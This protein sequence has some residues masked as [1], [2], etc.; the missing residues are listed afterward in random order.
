MW[1]FDYIAGGMEVSVDHVDL[2]KIQVRILPKD[3]LA[4]ILKDQGL[5]HLYLEPS[6]RLGDIRSNFPSRRWDAP[7]AFETFDEKASIAT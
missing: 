2:R 1:P 4:T 7:I 6:G 3:P 5:I